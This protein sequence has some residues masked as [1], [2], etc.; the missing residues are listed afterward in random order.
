[1]TSIGWLAIIILSVV[2]Y[3]MAVNGKIPATL[4]G[5]PQVVLDIAYAISVAEGFGEPGAIPTLAHN[6]GDLADPNFAFNWPGDT[7]GRLGTGIVVFATDQDGWNQL[8]KEVIAI[9]NG[10]SSEIPADSTIQ[11]A[12]GIYA[13]DS[14][15]WPANVVGAL[16]GRG[17][18]LPNGVD[19]PFNQIGA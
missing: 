12:G 13:G 18:S 4:G 7:G 3:F 14:V 9:R 8:Y 17:Y 11:Q 5:T 19:T 16:S 6:P 1:M 10:T 2:G 15:N